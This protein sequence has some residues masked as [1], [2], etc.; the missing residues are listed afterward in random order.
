MHRLKVC[1]FKI[2]NLWNWL[3]YALAYLNK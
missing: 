3:A 2:L 1:K